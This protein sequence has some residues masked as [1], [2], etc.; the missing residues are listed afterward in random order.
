LV[1]RLKNRLETLLSPPFWGQKELFKRSFPKGMG[2]MIND[3]QSS[4][5]EL[6]PDKSAF[7]L[8]ATKGQDGPTKKRYKIQANILNFFKK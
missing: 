1:K 5:F 2:A 4:L 7:A 6:R 8:R 3:Y